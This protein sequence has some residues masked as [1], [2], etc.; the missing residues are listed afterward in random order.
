M[1]ANAG[2]TEFLITH[3]ESQGHCLQ[4]FVETSPDARQKLFILSHHERLCE[5]FQE[6]ENVHKNF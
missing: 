2:R 6:G 1:N 5:A 4:R 3:Q